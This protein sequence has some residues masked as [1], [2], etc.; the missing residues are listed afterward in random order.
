MHHRLT[1]ITNMVPKDGRS[2]KQIFKIIIT[3]MIIVFIPTLLATVPLLES[4]EDFFVN[5]L[6]YTK[7]NNLFTGTVSKQLH[8]KIVTAYLGRSR[9]IDN[10]SLSWQQIRRLVRTMFSETYGGV[11]SKRTHF[12]GNSGVC[13]FKY[14]VTNKDPQVHQN[15][16]NKYYVNNE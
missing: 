8:M 9:I 16:D 2:I 13:V 15:L 6:H 7:D 3:C 14:L 12:Y 10:I 11:A 1:N 5:G 4:F